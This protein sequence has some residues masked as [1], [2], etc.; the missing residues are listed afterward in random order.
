MTLTAQRQ[1]RTTRAHT[2]SA[3]EI[4]EQRHPGP[5]SGSLS[6]PTQVST[7]R[8][9]LHHLRHPRPW[10]EGSHPLPGGGGVRWAART[11]L[12]VGLLL[13]VLAS[14]PRGEEDRLDPGPVAWIF[15]AIAGT[16]T[17]YCVRRL[18]LVRLARTPGPVAI[19]TVV[20]GT[21]TDAEPP[22][23]ELTQRLRMH[24][25]NVNIYP[26][27][28]VPGVPAPQD[29]ADIVEASATAK[30]WWERLVRILVALRPTHAYRV[31]CTVL[32][33][34]D[35]PEPYGAAVQL[36]LVPSWMS[37]PS[38]H[39]ASSWDEALKQAACAV[40]QHIVPWTRQ[41][42][43]PPWADWIDEEMDAGLLL[44]YEEAQRLTRARRYDEACAALV[45]ALQIDP[46]NLHLRLRLAAV[47]E[48]LALWMDALETYQSVH[49]IAESRLGDDLP[50]H[51][52]RRRARG[53]R[54]SVEIA[55]V[56][57]TYR[58]TVLLAWGDLVGRQWAKE[59]VRKATSS[60]TRRAAE[61]THLRTVLAPRL[62]KALN[63]SRAID[64]PD[65]LEEV[66]RDWGGQ[67]A[68]APEAVRRV[69]H[70]VVQ[71][72]LN[73]L[74]LLSARSETQRVTWEP[75]RIEAGGSR[76]SWKLIEV[77]T[78]Y[79]ARQTLAALEAVL[80]APG[81]PRQRAGDGPK[82]AWAA[83]P[84]VADELARACRTFLPRRPEAGSGENPPW[85]DWLRDRCDEIMEG[86]S[87]DWLDHY[88]AACVYAL[89]FSSVAWPDGLPA[90]RRR[91]DD[92]GELLGE[93][94]TRASDLALEAVE[95]LR[96]SMRLL[97]P[98]QLG[99]IAPWV[100]S[101]DP[102]LADLREHP[103]FARFVAKHFPG[104][105][106][107][108]RRPRNAHTLELAL[109]SAQAGRR[110]ARL[111]ADAWCERARQQPPTPEAAV[112]MWRIE[113]KCWKAVSSLATDHR[114]WQTRSRL[115][116]DLRS[117]ADAL[118]VPP[119]DV[120]HPAFDQVADAVFPAGK[121][122]G[123][124]AVE[125]WVGTCDDRFE[126]IEIAVG[127]GEVGLGVAKMLSNG[128]GLLEER[129]ASRRKLHRS[130]WL[131]LCTAE[132]HLWRALEAWL[133]DDHVS[134]KVPEDLADGVRHV[135]VALS[136]IGTSDA[137]A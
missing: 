8:E 129:S 88:N 134:A 33:R 20:D 62:V 45:R 46:G 53:I 50:K 48:K 43:R 97:K 104:A 116:A 52:V 122:A 41:G 84:G 106:R 121:P 87:K 27:S 22:L 85:A 26:H 72:L 98:N 78:E 31:H 120:A 75:W 42:A 19:L 112:A 37:S 47:Y 130:E 30:G 21:V 61:R 32:H 119:P 3:T 114:H 123:A 93:P 67:G 2:G 94:G 12:A 34:E 118:D 127:D 125:T 131:A 82:A 59:R 11:V 92:V 7:L 57:A 66:L 60:P 91:L 35:D 1:D 69:D 102:D 64:V 9:R 38:F 71:M 55:F 117:W 77:W 111:A 36:Q 54:R 103:R 39:W 113:R 10:L 81:L 25:A 58:R 40:G 83:L 29:F 115:I 16:A 110:A 65:G 51:P 15:L 63:D 14:L 86:T 90:D 74:A 126:S 100:C 89:P 107:E 95:S 132:A 56:L 137:G 73:I 128:Q 109:H 6:L 96:H 70:L 17:V 5:P 135:E 133:G 44:A 79:R 68:A 49:E 13:L 136:A 4:P 108:R 99:G 105:V 101:E 76:R 28:L 80:R 124:E 23:D 18:F 24:F